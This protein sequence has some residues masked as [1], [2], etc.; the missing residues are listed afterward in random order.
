MSE[1]TERW[2]RWTRRRFLTGAAAAV[3]AGMVAGCAGIHGRRMEDLDPRVPALLASTTSVDLH[4]HA[5]G[6]G[7]ARAPRFDLADHMRRGRLTAVCL[8][9]SAD[10][11]VIRR[12]P[13]AASA[14]T[15]IPPRASWRPTPGPASP[16]WTRW[17]PST[18]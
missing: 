8:C 11:P 1:E 14:S 16:S 9:H 18:G 12:P 15:A 5:A 2:P 3:A 17:W 7:Y 4:T 6:A 13:G 10:G